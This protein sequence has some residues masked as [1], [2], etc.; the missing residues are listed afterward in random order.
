MPSDRVG[1]VRRAAVL[2]VSVLALVVLPGT[3]VWATARSILEGSI[4]RLARAVSPGFGARAAGTAA[5]S[6]AASMTTSLATDTDGDGKAD[7]GDVIR[8]TTTITNGGTD[9]PGVRFNDTI[10][11][12]TTLV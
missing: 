1:A 2:G 5:P 8:Y 3:S 6:V 11:S 9:A 4:V 12:N 7:P 10:G